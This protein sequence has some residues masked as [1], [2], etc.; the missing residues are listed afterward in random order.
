MTNSDTFLNQLHGEEFE[1]VLGILKT[2]AFGE[3]RMKVDV[4]AGQ[5]AAAGQPK[6]QEPKVE[7]LEEAHAR[8]KGQN[9]EEKE[10]PKV[11][12]IKDEEPQLQPNGKPFTKVDDLD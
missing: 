5:L 4:L 11:E 10:E 2:P 9:E 7:T 8:I 1:Q 6:E 12:E 3:T